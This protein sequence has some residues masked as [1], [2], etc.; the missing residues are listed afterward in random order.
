MN[1]EKIEERVTELC[2]ARDQHRARLA[3]AEATAVQSRA[4]LQQIEGGLRECQRWLN[5]LAAE[6][7]ERTN[8]ISKERRETAPPSADI[9]ALAEET[10]Q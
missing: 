6:A 5:E 8:G 4:T 2:L 3:Q 10:P 9:Q 7:T 1:R